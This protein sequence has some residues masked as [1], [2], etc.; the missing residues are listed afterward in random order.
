MP[1]K[2][3]TIGSPPCPKPL[4]LHHTPLPPPRTSRPPRP[5]LN[6][7]CKNSSATTAPPP[8]PSNP[9]I[10]THL[11][12]PNYLS[13]QKPLPLINLP[14]QNRPPLNYLPPQ[15]HPTLNNSS[16]RCPIYRLPP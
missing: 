16:Q 3:L 10:T 13:P 15:N 7:S 6:S 11:R 2:A 8:P 1:S 4:N 5:P 9:P 12:L 14:L